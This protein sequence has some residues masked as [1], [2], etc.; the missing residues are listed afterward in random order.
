MKRIAALSFFVLTSAL[1]AGDLTGKWSGSLSETEGD[2]KSAMLVL[3]QAGSE[4]TGTAGPNEEK[5]FPIKNGKV[6]GDKVTFDVEAGEAV[7]HF[8]LTAAGNR[9]SGNVHAEHEGEKLSAKVEVTK[10]E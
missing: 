4:L 8:E 9:M 3:K 1:M 2:A 7:M 10:S 6:D 5:Q